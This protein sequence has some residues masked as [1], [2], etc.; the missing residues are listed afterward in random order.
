MTLTIDEKT[1]ELP[2]RLQA[3][4]EADAKAHGRGEG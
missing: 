3:T 4:L 1:I 2:P